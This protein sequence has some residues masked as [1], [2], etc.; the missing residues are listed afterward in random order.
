MQTLYPLLLIPEYIE[1]I[2]GSSDLGPLYSS[3]SPS[4]LIGEIWLTGDK[5]RVQNG[6]FAGRTL[7]EMVTGYR[8]VLVGTLATNP[9]RFPLLLKVLFPREKLSVQVHP[10]DGAAHA[11]GEDC[12][13]TECW[14]VL[15]AGPDAKVAAGLRPGTTIEEVKG[16][17]QE[18]RLEE[19]LNWIP[20]E[21]GEM[22]YVDAG[23]VHAI[24][25]GCVMLET[26][27]NSDTTYRLYDYGRPRELHLELGLAALKLK[28]SAGK[29]AYRQA[30]GYRS[31]VES[32]SFNVKQFSTNASVRMN[33]VSGNGLSS[34]H[35]IF[36]LHGGGRV[37]ALHAEGVFLSRGE[38]VVVPACAREYSIQAMSGDFEFLCAH[39][40]ADQARQISADLQEELLKGV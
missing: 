16:A 40:P 2:W 4:L 28:T 30:D 17:I 6:S 35:C 22:I 25:P 26:Q 32:P 24:G 29:V 12:G 7:A 31:L 8:E 20:I 27:Q 13:K 33:T 3:P 15:E 19:L 36:A 9:G 21:R 1:R 18:V 10:D 38:M 14:Y 34:V 37:D 11:A 5:C 23:T 39:L